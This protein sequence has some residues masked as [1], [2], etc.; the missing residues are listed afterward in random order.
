MMP[1]PQPQPQP[2]PQP[3][4]FHYKITILLFGI[5]LLAC[6]LYSKQS[7][8]S[9]DILRTKSEK[10][11]IDRITRYDVVY[12]SLVE[13]DYV[14]NVPSQ[15]V[16]RVKDVHFFRKK[17][18]SFPYPITSV[19]KTVSQIEVSLADGKKVLIDESNFTTDITEGSVGKEIDIEYDS[20]DLSNVSMAVDGLTSRQL[21]SCWSLIV[22]GILFIVIYILMLFGVI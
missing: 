1:P 9:K 10:T 17:G 8:E 21:W 3:I 11:K 12:R 5:V 22:V 20:N 4:P 13:S 6:G 2:Q 15:S 7:Y 19:T 18:S 14:Y 16:K